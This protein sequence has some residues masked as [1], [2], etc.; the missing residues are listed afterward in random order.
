MAGPKISF[1]Y[2]RGHDW[3]E[4]SIE[5][6]GSMPK[7]LKNS[8]WSWKKSDN[9]WRKYPSRAKS[10]I[11]EHWTAPDAYDFSAWRYCKY[12]SNLL[13]KKLPNLYNSSMKF[14]LTSIPLIRMEL[15]S[16][17]SDFINIYITFH[18]AASLGCPASIV[19]YILKLSSWI[20]KSFSMFWIIFL[21]WTMCIQ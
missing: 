16:S 14:E 19:S 2:C 17:S 1:T 6:G 11:C 9:F 13:Y 18:Q 3:P 5:G 12:F 21:F 8:H 15:L 10:T 20:W 7:V 4:K